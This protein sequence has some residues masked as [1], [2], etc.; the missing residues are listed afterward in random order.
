MFQNRCS[1]NSL[2]HW[3]PHLYPFGKSWCLKHYLIFL[4]E[5]N[6]KI[7]YLFWWL[8]MSLVS[9]YDPMPSSIQSPTI[10]HVCCALLLVDWHTSACSCLA[11]LWKL[12]LGK[13]V[14]YIHWSL[15]ITDSTLIFHVS[16]GQWVIGLPFLL[17]V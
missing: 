1:S 15:Y 8:F 13:L 3:V 16:Q 4:C 10:E 17:P 6:I 14:G 5:M 11:S 12:G 2:I 7:A 9:C